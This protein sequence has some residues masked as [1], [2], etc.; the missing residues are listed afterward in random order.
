MGIL[1]FCDPLKEKQ[2]LGPVGERFSI[3]ARTGALHRSPTDRLTIGS[4]I[5]RR[6]QLATSQ[7]FCSSDLVLI[8]KGLFA[9]FP[10]SV[11]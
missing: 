9:K 11:L 7:V 5:N 10:A 3:Y 1:I 8:A 4:G 6:E 2:T